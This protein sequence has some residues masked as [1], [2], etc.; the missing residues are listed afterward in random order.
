MAANV[1]YC[2]T[3]TVFPSWTS[4]V[5]V[6]SPAPSFNNLHTSSNQLLSHLSQLDGD[7]SDCSA[8]KSDQ[9]AATASSLRVSDESTYSAK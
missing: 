6:P 3:T 8:L 2:E 4:R 5:R 7:A 9:S 1:L